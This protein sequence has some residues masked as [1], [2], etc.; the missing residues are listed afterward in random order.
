[1]SE[2]NL[3]RLLRHGAPDFGHAV[4]NADDCGLAGSVEKSPAVVSDDP[5]TFPAS[6]NG[7]RFLKIAREKTAARRHEMSGRE[8]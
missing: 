6:S 7:K 5:A 8:L 4:T 3:R 2:C 1:M